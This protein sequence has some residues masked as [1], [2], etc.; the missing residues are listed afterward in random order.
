MYACVHETWA[1][2]FEGLCTPSNATTNFCD[3]PPPRIIREPEPRHWDSGPKMITSRATV[4][5]PLAWGR[6]K[7]ALAQCPSTTHKPPPHHADYRTHV[8]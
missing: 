8:P 2:F 3:P 1:G 5:G 4:S 6:G 7:P